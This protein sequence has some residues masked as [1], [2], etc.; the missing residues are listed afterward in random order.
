MYL[1][2][3]A[4]YTNLHWTLNYPSVFGV[5]LSSPLIACFL[6]PSSQA[7]FLVGLQPPIA[8][9]S[10]PAEQSL[11][12]VKF[13]DTVTFKND[14]SNWKGSEHRI[15]MQVVLFPIVALM[16][17]TIDAGIILLLI[18]SIHKF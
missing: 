2:Y 18:V 10:P 1:T 9:L 12:Y 8:V 16:A 7:Y 3:F 11:K 14:M 13:V 4:F 15:C 6:S 17:T 5:H